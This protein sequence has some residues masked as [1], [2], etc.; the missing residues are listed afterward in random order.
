MTDHTHGTYETVGGRPALRFERRLAHPVADVWRAVTDPAEL[1]HWFPQEVQV[2]EWRVG[3][4]VTLTFAGDDEPA[5]TSDRVVEVDPPHLLS[6]TWFGE[7]LTFELQPMDDGAATLLTFTHHLGDVETAAR[8]AAGWH[9]CLDSLERH[10]GG[11][12]TTAPGPDA[13]ESWRALYDRYVTDG[14]PSGAPV[15][16]GT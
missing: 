14:V 4:T 8:S 6:F 15:P 10:L 16:G 9:V 1:A 5:S 7:I 13:T 12:A 2:D 11:E 3:A